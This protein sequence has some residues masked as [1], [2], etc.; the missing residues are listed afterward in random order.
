M[1]RVKN[2]YRT[3]SLSNYNRF[4]KAH[5]SIQISFDVWKSILYGYSEL[6]RDYVLETGE[7]CKMPYGMGELSVNKKKQARFKKYKDVTYVALAIDWQASKQYGKHIYHMNTHTDG[8]RFKWM[9][10]PKKARF[11]LS[12]LW[13]FKPSRVTSRTL[14]QYINKD[15]KY[16]SI[17]REWRPRRSSSIY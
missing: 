9:W 13:S 6:L 15:A 14:A 16:Q 11:K 2:S 10:F 12:S 4:R 17:Y 5:P 7:K 8:Y 1:P 3:A